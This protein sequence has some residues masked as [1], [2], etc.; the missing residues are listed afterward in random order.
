MFCAIMPLQRS[1]ILAQPYHHMDGGMHAWHWGLGIVLLVLL[2]AGVVALVYFL[3]R[4]AGQTNKDSL[5]QETP[6]ETLKK[7]YARG[8]ISQEQFEQMKKDM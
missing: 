6:L 3:T 2:I 8:E 5:Q 7:R 1:G 4:Q